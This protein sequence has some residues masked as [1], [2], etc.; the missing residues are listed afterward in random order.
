MGRQR[1]SNALDSA[2]IAA[3]PASTAHAAPLSTGF[4]CDSPVGDVGWVAQHEAARKQVERGFGAE[5]RLQ[6]AKNVKVGPDGTRVMRDLIG[7]GAGLLVRASFGC[8]NTGLSRA[9]DNPK[10]HFVHDS[11][12]KL[13]PNFGTYKAR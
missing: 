13:L 1:F 3:L 8:L 5:I 12:Y 4:I 7:D 6:V 10:V 2:W 11:G 9:A